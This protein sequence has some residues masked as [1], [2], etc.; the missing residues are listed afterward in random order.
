MSGPGA[1]Y[2]FI[3]IRGVIKLDNSSHTCD[4][5]RGTKPTAVW[6]TDGFNQKHCVSGL[7][8]GVTH[9]TIFPVDGSR[10]LELYSKGDLVRVGKS[11]DHRWAECTFSGK[12]DLIRVSTTF[13]YDTRLSSMCSDWNNFERALKNTQAGMHILKDGVAIFSQIRGK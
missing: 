2:E 3:G 11:P 4:N 10:T 6:F 8:E 7:V 12:G 9:T 1:K 13:F 5:I